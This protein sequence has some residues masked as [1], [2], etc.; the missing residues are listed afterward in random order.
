M[1]IK[2]IGALTVVL[3][4]VATSLGLCRLFSERIR[5]LEGFLK[6]LRHTRE[7]IACFHTPTP[8]IFASFQNAALLSA[9]FLEPL[10]EHGFAEALRAA[11]GRL[12]LDE[13]ELEPLLSFAEALGGGFSEE[14]TARCDLAIAALERALAERREGLPR[15]A[16]LCR[17]LFLG[18]GLMLVIVLI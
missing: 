10:C 2:L 16:K 18:A 6:L 4:A 17:T 3:S 15:M 12:L 9:G 8:E 1:L 11:R 5:Q 14:E 7:R 13:E